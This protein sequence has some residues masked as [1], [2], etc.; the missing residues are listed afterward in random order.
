LGRR[1]GAGVFRSAHLLHRFSISGYVEVW[2]PMSQATQTTDLRTERKISLEQEYEV[3]Y[4]T[5]ALRVTED[6]LRQL[7]E[8][9][10][11]NELTV[12]EALRKSA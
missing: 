6:Y 3:R 7:I 1:I 5:K 11:A 8:R 12:R 2:A 9:H 10:G 4:W